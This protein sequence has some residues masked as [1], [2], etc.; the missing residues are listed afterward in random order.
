MR[1][2][3]MKGWIL[4]ELHYPDHY[5]IYQILHTVINVWN[6]FHI[7]ALGFVFYLQNIH[8]ST[9]I[10]KTLFILESNNKNRYYYFIPASSPVIVSSFHSK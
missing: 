10:F 8:H 6:T 7:A 3:S 5:M 4:F 1:I 9:F 2:R